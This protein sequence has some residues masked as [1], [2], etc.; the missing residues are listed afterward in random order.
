MAPEDELFDRENGRSLIEDPKLVND[1]WPIGRHWTHLEKPIDESG[2]PK[3]G[4]PWLIRIIR[5]ELWER[6]PWTNLGVPIDNKDTKQ[7]LTL[8]QT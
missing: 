1:S 4:G 7:V 6:M 3:L 5:P 8:S 2:S